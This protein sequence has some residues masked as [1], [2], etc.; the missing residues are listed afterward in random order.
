M[1]GTSR[2][3]CGIGAHSSAMENL[4]A[5]STCNGAEV[6]NLCWAMPLAHALLVASRQWTCYAFPG[7]TGR[8]AAG[9]GLSLVSSWAKVAQPPPGH[10]QPE[11]GGGLADPDM[12]LGIADALRAACLG[13]VD[14]D[15]SLH[16]IERVTDVRFHLLRTQALQSKLVYQM[17]CLI[18]C[19]VLSG[20][21]RSA[22]TLGDSIRMSIAAAI[23]D[24]GAK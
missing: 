18:P 2:L 8:R 10:G 11:A 24:P 21:L 19:L 4:S 3:S 15:A 14:R 22:A 6:A 7:E 17:N 5:T 20:L 12:L 13:H 16:F 1:G 23:Q 9:L